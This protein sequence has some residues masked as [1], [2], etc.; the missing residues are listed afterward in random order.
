MNTPILPPLP[1]HRLLFAISPTEHLFYGVHD[2]WVEQANDAA[3][4]HL[5]QL[6]VD[7]AK[8]E[9]ADSGVRFLQVAQLPDA[10]CLALAKQRTVTCIDGHMDICLLLS[11][12]QH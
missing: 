7:L 1:N 9:K 6:F 8:E 12:T 11:S 2:A 4:I 10:V 5:P 3:H